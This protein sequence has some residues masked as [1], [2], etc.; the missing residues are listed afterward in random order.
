MRTA[1]ET[2]ATLADDFY[3]GADRATDI[4][5]QVHQIT[6]QLDELLNRFGSEAK[7]NCRAC[8]HELASASIGFGESLKYCTN[9]PAPILEAVREISDLTGAEVL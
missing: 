5:K 4:R 3:Y 7:D 9:C 6:Q 2:I 8:G 1:A